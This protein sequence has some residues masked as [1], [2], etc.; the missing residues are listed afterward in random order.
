MLQ[1]KDELLLTKEIH[2]VGIRKIILMADLNVRK[3]ERKLRIGQYGEDI[4]KQ[5]FTIDCED[6]FFKIKKT[7][8]FSI[9]IYTDIH[10]HNRGEE[11]NS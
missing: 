11:S 6:F 10:G 8:S 5:R 4:F 9:R 1:I 7:D 3:I 2:K